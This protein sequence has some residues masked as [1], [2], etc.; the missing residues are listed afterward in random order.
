M[1]LINILLMAGQQAGQKPESQYG[2]LIMMVLLFVVFYF[3]FIRPQQKKAKEVK[4]FREG[5]KK[6][7]RVITIGGI[8][9]KISEI[10]DNVAFVEVDNNVTLKFNKDALTADGTSEQPLQPK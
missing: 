9:G 4:K 1:Q 3:F 5:L 8:H 7:D 10:R 6:G 2:T